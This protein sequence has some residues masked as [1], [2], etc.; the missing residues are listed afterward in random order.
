MRF[1]KDSRARVARGPAVTSLAVLSAL[2]FLQAQPLDAVHKQR[3]AMGTMFD[4]VV[5]HPSREEAERAVAKAIDEIFRLDQVMSHF[6]ADSDL[7]KLIREGRRREV[8]VEPSLY[9][10]IQESLKFSRLS[11]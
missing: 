5:Y 2:P 7:S 1:G 8:T 3:Y 11:G 10:V 6:D 4:I 9:E